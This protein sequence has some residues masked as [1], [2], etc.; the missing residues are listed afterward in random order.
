MI[1][2]VAA[3]VYSYLPLGLR[4]LKKVEGIVHE[5][6]ERLGAQELFMPVLQ[7]LE[8]WRETGR[9]L[10]FGK[11]LF[12][13]RDRRDRGL[14]LAPTHEEVITELVAHNV[15]SYRD[16]PLYLYQIQTKFRDEP[17]PRAGLIRLREF[18]MQDL[19]SFDADDEG[20][21]E[22][23][24]KMIQAYANIFARCGLPSL[25][26]AADSG[27][28]G[29]K[30]SHEFMVLAESGEDQ[31]IYCPQCSYAANVERASLAKSRLEGDEP[32]PLEEV[33]TPGV[34]SIDDL[35]RFLALPKSQTLKAVFYFADDELIFVAIRGDLEVNEVK[36]R[37]LLGCFELRLATE[38]EVQ[39]A[40]LVA[41]SASPIGI[42][43]I[44]KVGDDSITMGTNFVVGGNKPNI[45]LRNANYPRDFAVDLLADIA[46]AQAGHRCP[47]CGAE[48]RSTRGIEV[49]HL[50]KLGTMFSSKLGAYYLDRE[51]KQR[52]ITM[53]CYGIGLS[54][55]LA[56]AVEHNHDDR[57]IIWPPSIAPYQ[58]YLCPL[59]LDKP[60]IAQG[61]ERLYHQLCEQGFEVLFDDRLES[62]GVKF[63]DA[64]LLGL[65]LRLT[66]S[67]RTLNIHS[68]EIKRRTE[69]EAELVPLERVGE[70][71]IALLA[72]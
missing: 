67:P 31:V 18:S 66:L 56:A 2:Q 30:E 9:N 6:M 10:A 60:E 49:G 38:E 47:Q 14:C 58:V 51:G 13:L 43:G 22:S 63:N 68:A 28:I 62:P 61:V 71:L 39:G 52:P 70:R 23:Y 40:G 69:R 5:E 53:G 17:R 36:L 29:G 41:G 45:H 1:H 26:V 64:D 44:K 59:N 37:N 25:L 21:N 4:V 35:A 48:L 46:L 3:G 33:K 55:L 32:L 7:P 72:A 34:G 19:Y 54:R 11:S 65:P 57:G 16:L 42:L 8:V 12:I 15:K 27:A 24:R 20:L 50:F